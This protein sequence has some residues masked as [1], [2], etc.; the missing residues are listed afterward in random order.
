MALGAYRFTLEGSSAT[1]SD[2]AAVEVLAPGAPDDVSEAIDRARALAAATV[3]ARD[4]ANAR[5][6]VKTPDWLGRQAAAI[7]TPLGVQVD[8]HEETW[9][10]AQGFGG[11]LAVGAG[12]M[13]PPRLIRA[14][15]RPRNSGPAHL[16]IIGKGITFDSGGLNLKPGDSMRTM[17]TDMAGAA[18]ALGALRRL[19]P[20]DFL[21]GSPSSFPP[22][23]TACP[24]RRCARATSSGITAAGRRRCRTRTPKAALC[25][26]TRSPMRSP[27]SGPLP[28]WISPRL[29]VP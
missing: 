21:S 17:Y 18:A 6:S 23:R 19:L 27:G 16:A 29:P 26:P 7:L 8:V 2:L 25:S 9:L 11:V 3:W 1:E 14:A 4:L 20:A 10:A 15:W 5:S 13:S 22:P 24:A 28:W 12:S